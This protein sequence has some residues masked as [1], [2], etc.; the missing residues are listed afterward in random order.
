MDTINATDATDNKGTE[1][2]ESEDV[3]R[4]L[5]ALKKN[6]EMTQRDL[7]R[8]VGISLGKANFILKALIQKGLVKT[9]N[10]KNSSNKK[11]YLY[12]LTPSGIEEKAKITYRFL[13]RKI[14]EYE[15]LEE[16][17]R[18]LRREVG[19]IEPVSKTETG[20]SQNL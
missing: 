18:V 8:M 2:H 11:A 3:L 14:Q 7:A 6:P 19:E 1:H 10:F 15:R 16:Q 4:I 5:Q 17:I 13:K 20:S 12:I 9:H